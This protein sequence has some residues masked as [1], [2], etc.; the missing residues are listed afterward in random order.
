MLPGMPPSYGGQSLSRRAEFA[1]GNLTW[2]GYLI[3]RASQGDSSGEL[4]PKAIIGLAAVNGFVWL[5][6]RRK[7]KTEDNG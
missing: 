5:I 1:I 2:I 6:T 3:Y 7:T 4:L